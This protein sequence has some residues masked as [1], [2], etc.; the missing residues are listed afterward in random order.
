M[1]VNFDLVCGIMFGMEYVQADPEIDV[2]NS[3][4]VIDFGC[5]RWILEFTGQ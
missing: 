3:C 4:L 5:F 2:P 1:E